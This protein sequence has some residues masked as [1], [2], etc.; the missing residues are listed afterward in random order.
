MMM[1]FEYLL[2]LCLSVSFYNLVD[3]NGCFYNWF[4]KFLETEQ[5]ALESRRT[6]V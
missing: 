3:N 4:T 2:P 1:S 5:L 6:L